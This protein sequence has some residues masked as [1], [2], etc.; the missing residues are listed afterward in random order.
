MRANRDPLKELDSVDRTLIAALQRDG[1]MGYA[2]MAGLVG[3]TAG[4]ARRRVVRLQERGLLQVVGVTDPLKLGYRS[5]AM[6]SIVAD[7]DVAEI[8]D[9]IANVDDVIYVVI[10]GD[11][12]LLRDPHTPVRLGHRRAVSTPPTLLRSDT[13]DLMPLPAPGSDSRG[14]GAGGVPARRP[15]G[16]HHDRHR[17]R[18]RAEVLVQQPTAV[19]IRG[20]HP[21]HGVDR[22]SSLRP[23]DAARRPRLAGLLLQPALVTCTSSVRP[24]DRGVQHRGDR[25]RLRRGRRLHGQGQVRRASRHR[26]SSGAGPARRAVLNVPR[27]RALDGASRRCWSGGSAAGSRRSTC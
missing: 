21:V 10:G 2:E 9:A 16:R 22:V 20:G 3:L 4:G 17:R 18:R 6:L 1:R 8:A 15:A 26:I 25:L 12:H 5:M 13:E 14:P 27:D 7:G 24:G 19:G 11:V 23:S